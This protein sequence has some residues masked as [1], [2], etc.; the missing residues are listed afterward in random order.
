[1]QPRNRIP[2]TNTAWRRFLL[3]THLATKQ[4]MSLAKWLYP[5]VDQRSD[6]RRD[7]PPPTNPIPPED[8]REEGE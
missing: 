8:S 7:S 6:E 3:Q 4:D 1:M 2:K 5:R